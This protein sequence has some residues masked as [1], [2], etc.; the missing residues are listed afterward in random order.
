MIYYLEINNKGILVGY[1]LTVPAVIILKTVIKKKR[2]NILFTDDGFVYQC[3]N[4][5]F[6]TGFHLGLSLNKKNLQWLDDLGATSEQIK[7]LKKMIKEYNDQCNDESSEQKIVYRPRNI[8]KI[9]EMYESINESLKNKVDSPTLTK[10][11]NYIVQRNPHLLE[12]TDLM[13]A[14]GQNHFLI[15]CY[16]FGEV[17]GYT[18]RSLDDYAKNKYIHYTPE[19]YVHN[20]DSLLKERKY[21]I[22]CEGDLDALAVDGIGILSSEFTP[23][24]LKRILTYNNGQE[25]IVCPDRDKAGAKLVKQILDED[26]P[27]SVSF[28]NWSRGI[29]DVEEATKLI[30]ELSTETGYIVKGEITS[31]DN[32]I[33]ITVSGNTEYAEKLA[34]KIIDS[35]NKMLISG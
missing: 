10:V 27:F 32:T 11:M 13:W 25:L 30:L 31:T 22:L 21:N 24:R 15:P 26:L 2:G 23:E 7:T 9:P 1:I 16:E 3:F 29:K 4:C 18:L 5:K 20:F 17:V 8:R 12:W 33:N 28:P 34:N 6:K 14:E 35:G 19:G